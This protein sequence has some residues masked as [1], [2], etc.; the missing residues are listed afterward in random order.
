MKQPSI[1]VYTHDSV[2][3][4]EDGPT[5]QPVEQIANLRSTPNLHT[6]RPCDVTESAVCWKAAIERRDGPI[7]LIFTRQNLAHQKRDAK[8]VANIE[9]GAYVLRET[10]GHPD[11][12]LIAT[13]S[14]V[15]LAMT[16]AEQ[17]ASNGRNVRVVSMPCSTL[18]D[19]QDIEYRE[20][21]LPSD[22]FARVAVEAAHKDFWYKYVGLDGAIIGM[23]TF[24]ESAPGPQLME[25]FGFTVDA[26]V[27]TVNELLDR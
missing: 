8:Q 24:G 21:V 3:L 9:R 12:I 20:S 22:V 23:E 4:G 11:A 26:V 6:W 25:H 5:H 19:E 15:A 16:A 13:G 10:A 14:E 2:A 27:D 1:F 18:F 7:A 17:L